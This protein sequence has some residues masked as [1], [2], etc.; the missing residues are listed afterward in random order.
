MKNTRTLSLPRLVVGSTAVLLLASACSG[1]GSDSADTTVPDTSAATTTPTTA[2]A[3]T[4]TAGATTTTAA[5]ATTTTVA[6]CAA[7]APLTG[8]CLSDPALAKRTA[9]VVKIDNHAEAVPQTGLNE[10]D[11]VYEELVEGISRFASVFQSQTTVPVGELATIGPIR[12]GRTSDVDIVAALGKPLFA[13]SGGNDRVTKQIRSANLVDV[14][15]SLRSKEG[16]YFRDRGRSAPHNL[17][18]NML[19]LFAQQKPDQAPPAP[20]FSFRAPGEAPLSAARAIDGVKLKFS[21]KISQWTWD[22]AGSQWVRSQS[23]SPSNPKPHNDASGTQLNAKNVVVLFTPYG[24]TNGSPEAKTVGKGTAWVFTDGKVIEGCWERPDKT[25]GAAL[26]LCGTTTPIAL[27][28]GRTWVELPE[29]D[30]TT[31]NNAAL[32]EPGVDPATVKP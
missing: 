24:S 3:T 14:G 26:I 20:L 30:K 7:V 22:G 27:T 31:P 28:P 15:Y 29:A 21:G 12:S 1:G 4:T 19:A 16:G 8:L 10:A 2:A 5:S 23:E 13:W 18:A 32:I 9:L 11:V 25:K 17:Y 6:P